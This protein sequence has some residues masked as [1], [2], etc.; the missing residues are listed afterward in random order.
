MTD[1]EKLKKTFDEIGCE[2]EVERQC[3]LVKLPWDGKIITFD[4]IIAIDYDGIGDYFICY[5]YFLNGKFQ[6]HGC[7]E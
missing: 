3:D 6:G 4:Q 5:F 2:Y 1:F 7:W